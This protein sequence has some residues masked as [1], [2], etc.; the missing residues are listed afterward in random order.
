MQWERGA[1]V[2]E[3]TSS[4]WQQWQQ[5][6]GY[7]RVPTVYNVTVTVGKQPLFDPPEHA[8]DGAKGATEPKKVGESAEEPTANPL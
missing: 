7:R 3:V 8:L 6:R 4:S 5:P 1:H 2:P